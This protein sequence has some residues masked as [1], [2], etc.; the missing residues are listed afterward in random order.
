MAHHKET[1]WMSLKKLKTGLPYDPETL[2]G[3]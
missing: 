1:V 3:I 2:L